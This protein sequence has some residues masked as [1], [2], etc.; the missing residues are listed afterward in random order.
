MGDW[1]E[2]VRTISGVDERKIMGWLAQSGAQSWSVFKTGLST[3][4]DFMQNKAK[5][6]LTRLLPLGRRQQMD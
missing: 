3:A 2:S 1:S 6:G 4:Q 5:P